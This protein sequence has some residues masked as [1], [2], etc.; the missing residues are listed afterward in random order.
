MTIEE[1]HRLVANLDYKE[2]H[3]KFAP[4]HALVQFN[5]TGEVV[6]VSRFKCTPDE[7]Q[8]YEALAEHPGCL[9]IFS[10]PHWFSSPKDLQSRINED[11]W[12]FSKM[13]QSS[14]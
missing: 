10:E 11:L 1:A 6:G 9:Q 3:R 2:G 8:Q 13:K 12:L 7:V 4:K 5:R 14:S